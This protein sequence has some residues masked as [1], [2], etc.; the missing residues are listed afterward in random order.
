LL[1][2]DADGNAGDLDFAGVGVL[3]GRAIVA[4]GS[5][6][7]NVGDGSSEVPGAEPGDGARGGGSESVATDGPA[8]G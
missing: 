7:R 5:T 2:A 6:A 8:D 3:F 1:D 4:T